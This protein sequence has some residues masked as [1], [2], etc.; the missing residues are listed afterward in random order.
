MAERQCTPVGAA[1]ETGA[2]FNAC[3]RPKATDSTKRGIS[4][5]PPT[6]SR[7]A[8]PTTSSRCRKITLPEWSASELHPN[9]W[10]C[11][12]RSWEASNAPGDR[13][14][15]VGRHPDLSQTTE[16]SGCIPAS[17]LQL[18]R[19]CG[20][21]LVAD[22]TQAPSEGCCLGSRVALVDN[23]TDGPRSELPSS[24]PYG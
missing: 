19:T 14:R 2:T 8:F 11:G 22:H 17:Q 20:G 23:P 12:A 16:L 6:V 10:C 18:D 3:P 9:H 1:K 21:R 24:W 5:Q 7:P 15:K 13:R 4:Y